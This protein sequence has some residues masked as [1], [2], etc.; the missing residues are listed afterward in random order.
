MTRLARSAP[1]SVRAG[2]AGHSTQG[3][4]QPSNPGR[5]LSS[6]CAVVLLAMTTSTDAIAA[7][8][9]HAPV[10]G[11]TTAQLVYAP[12]SSDSGW[13]PF[14][15]QGGSRIM[16]PAT[17]NGRPTTVMLD[18]GASVSV[19]DH[20][21]VSALQLTAQGDHIAEGAGGEASYST[22][23]GVV[24]ALG[25]LTISNSQTVA[26]DLQPLAAAINH[27]LPMV[28]GGAAFDQTVVDIDFANQRLAFRDPRHFKPPAG[29]REYP[30]SVAGD[31]RAITIE[32]EGRPARMLFDLG[33]AWPAVLYPRFWDRPDFLRER[34]V[35]STMTGGWGG[36]HEEGLTRLRRV[37]VAGTAFAAVPAP[38]KAERTSHERDG[39]LDGNLG[40]PI[41]QRFHLIVDFPGSKVMFGSVRDEQARFAAS[42]SGIALEST[43]QGVQV[44]HV[45]KSSPAEVL[46]LRRGDAI[47]QVEQVGAS[48]TVD[49][50]G[51]WTSAPPGMQ[52]R[53]TLG[54][55]R[56]VTLV[57]QD[58]F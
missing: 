4:Q 13:I 14:Q 24:I 43:T 33:N 35:S 7:D 42:T 48:S 31:N 45:A 56:Q 3:A 20:A 23:Q 11:A 26:V 27:A 16:L 1:A 58:Y 52:Y 10:Q 53:L 40:M 57:S 32:V 34:V 49:V 36:M 38:L 50:L 9:Q 19:L 47:V 54:D 37:Q 29:Y 51:G 44:A 12:G 15:L 41:L 22:V 18:S 39:L 30:L 21:L 17:V 6:W 55:G 8:G 28:V 25:K 2:A 5:W 46:G